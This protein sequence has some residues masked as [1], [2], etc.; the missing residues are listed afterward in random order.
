ME[1]WNSWAVSM[2]ETRVGST[3][4]ALVGVAVTVFATSAISL[5]LID[6]KREWQVA[7]CLVLVAAIGI[8]VGVRIR[9]VS[10]F[11]AAATL[12]LGSSLV[13]AINDAMLNTGRWWILGLIMFL[14]GALIVSCAATGISRAATG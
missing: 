11:A 14:P 13:F 10:W 9:H 1:Q 5:W 6:L 12:T 7:I 4:S 2:A 3:G 8:A